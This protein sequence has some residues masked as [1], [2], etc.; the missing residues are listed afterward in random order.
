M[1]D[2]W[3]KLGN[4]P[5]VKNVPG[6]MLGLMN[7]PVSPRTMDVLNGQQMAINAIRAG[8][9]TNPIIASANWYSGAAHWD[10]VRTDNLPFDPDTGLTSTGG[11][12]EGSDVANSAVMHQLTDPLGPGGH[13]YIDVHQYF[14]PAN[15]QGSDVVNAAD[16]ALV[17]ARLALPTAWA[18]AHG[19]KL[20]LGEFGG[21]NSASVQLAV[22]T[23]IQYL[24]DNA[25]VWR[26]WTWW[27]AGWRPQYGGPGGTQAPSNLYNAGV[28]R[29]GDP[30]GE[31]ARGACAQLNPL[32]LC[33]DLSRNFSEEQ[34]RHGDGGADGHARRRGHGAWRVPRGV[35]REQ[36]RRAGVGHGA[37]ARRAV[38]HG[39]RRA[40]RSRSRTSRSS[41]ASRSGTR[42]VMR[43]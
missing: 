15:V 8:G 30:A 20:I 25:D 22:Q 1:R 16:P 3:G 29:L 11:M 10:H 37:G 35:D 33:N 14:D 18:R 7:E 9:A 21:Q 43:I 39:G 5:G 27:W 26:G 6:V 31:L 17:R 12:L 32:G 42:W 13:P 23:T 4:A 36:L 24:A 2:F 38:W 34:R 41:R 40:A 19:I 28:W